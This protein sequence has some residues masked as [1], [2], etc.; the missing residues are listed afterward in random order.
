M[1][2]V[3]TTNIVIYTNTTFEQVFVLEDTVSNSVLNL[4]NYTGSAQL[5]RYKSSSI[6]ATFTTQVNSGGFGKVRIELDADQTKS[7]K[8]GKY[9]YDLNIT[10]TLTGEKTRVVEGTAIVKQSVTR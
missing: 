5:R 8:P 10:N 1:A 3:Y 2:A 6:A 7:I 4:T 9:F